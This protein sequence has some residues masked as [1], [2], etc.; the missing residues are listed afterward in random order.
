MFVFVVALGC[1]WHCI[2]KC[3]DIGKP[4]IEGLVQGRRNPIANALELRCSRTKPSIY[5]YTEPDKHRQNKCKRL[6]TDICE[7]HV[8]NVDKG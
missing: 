5:V 1:W 8:C 2:T 7:I 4:H 3:L 6:F